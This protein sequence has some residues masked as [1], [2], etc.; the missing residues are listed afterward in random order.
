ML[1][2]MPVRGQVGQ[3]MPAPSC[4]HRALLVVDVAEQCCG[5]CLSTRT[6]RRSTDGHPRT[7]HPARLRQSG[8]PRPGRRRCSPA[9]AC[10]VSAIEWR[11]IPWVRGKKRWAERAE[12]AETPGTHPARRI[13]QRFQ[14]SNRAGFRRSA[15][16]ESVGKGRKVPARTLREKLSAIFL[17]HFWG[18]LQKRLRELRKLTLRGLNSSPPRRTRI[19]AL[20]P[21][22]KELLVAAYSTV[23]T[24]T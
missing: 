3:V 21:G 2:R 8:A 22:G 11:R 12:R 5:V 24:F 18:A 7:S 10:G 9:R 23:R 13:R 14:S 4:I 6:C 16:P 19:F 15:W 17:S 20:S 1:W